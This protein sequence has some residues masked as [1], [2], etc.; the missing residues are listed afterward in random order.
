M[1]RVRRSL[2]FG[3]GR[4]DFAMPLLEKCENAYRWLRGGRVEKRDDVLGAVLQ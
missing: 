2:V 4:A 3:S 1:L